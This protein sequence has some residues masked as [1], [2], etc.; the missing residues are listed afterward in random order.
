MTEPLETRIEDPKKVKYEGDYVY[1]DGTRHTWTE[2][3]IKKVDTES[4]VG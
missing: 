3:E 1:A 4:N 2:T